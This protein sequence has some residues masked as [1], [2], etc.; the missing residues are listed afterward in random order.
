MILEYTLKLDLKFRFINVGVQKIVSFTFETFTIVLAS[1]Q[2]KN[3]LGKAQ[4]FQ[5][6]FLLTDFNIKIVLE[7]LF[8][9]L[10]NANIQFA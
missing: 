4:F 10:S 8:F 2:V 1:F 3:K 5:E 6:M 9:T 7:M